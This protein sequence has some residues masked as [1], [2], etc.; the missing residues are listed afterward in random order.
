MMDRISRWLSQG[1]MFLSAAGLVAMMLIIC[2]QVV[3]RYVL[4]AAPSWTEQSALYL[5]LWFIIFAAAAGVRESFH[6]RLSL[7]QDTSPP[8]RRKAMRLFCHGVVGVFAAYMLV[9]GGQLVA[10]TWQHDIPTLG[11]PR[12][13]AYLPIPISGAMIVFFCVEHIL[14]EWQGREVEPLWN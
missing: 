11:L 8:A 2:W 9:A 4:H 13:S 7:L 10:A 12:G 14:T 5:M 3:A 6:I 1:A